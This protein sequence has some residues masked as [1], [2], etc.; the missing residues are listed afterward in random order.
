[1][2]LLA[3]L[4]LFVAANGAAEYFT[5]RLSL[6]ITLIGLV[7]CLFGREIVKLARFELLFLIFMVPVPYLIYYAATVPMQLLASKITVW[8]LNL[9]GAEAIRQGNIIYLGNV[10]LEVAEACS[11][12]RSL[13]SLL[14]LGCLY[15]H[16]SQKRASA[17]LILFVST[18]PIAVIG[19]AFRVFVTSLLAYTVTEN[20]TGEPLHTILGLSVFGVAFVMLFALATILRR[21]YR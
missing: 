9:I 4:L 7:Y 20:V 12:M 3:G 6:V 13:V 10:A 21:L 16:L 15:A 5:L 19:N 11:G 8:A 18:V 17:K 1:M 2:V 14:A